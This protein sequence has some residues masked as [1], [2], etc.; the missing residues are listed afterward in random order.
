VKGQP[1]FETQLWKIGN[2]KFLDPIYFIIYNFTIP[3]QAGIK[4]LKR[5]AQDMGSFHPSVFKRR[6]KI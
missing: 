3:K 1:F 4:N 6:V 5:S 2:I